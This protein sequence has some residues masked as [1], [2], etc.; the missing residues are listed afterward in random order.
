MKECEKGIPSWNQLEDW[1]RLLRRT[2]EFFEKHGFLEVV[3]PLLVPAGAF[4]SSLDCL[5][6][7]G[8]E[9]ECELPTSPEIGMKRILSHFNE[10]IYQICK[11]F[12]DEMTTSFHLKEFTM[13][14]FYQPG[15]SYEA[16]RE[17]MV[18]YLQSLSNEPMGVERVTVNE[19]FQRNLQL[20]LSQLSELEDFR[21]A[22]RER[23]LTQID[24][25]DTWPDLFFRL[26]LEKI[27]PHLDPR[28]PVMVSGY[29]LAVS[30]L[31]E[32]DADN[33][34][35]KRFEIYWRGVELC[36]GCVELK[37]HE[38]LERRYA[39]ESELR[40]RR[41]RSPHPFPA[42]LY[43]AMKKMPPAAGV[44]VGMERLFYCLFG[45]PIN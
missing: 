14:E 13:L 31:S 22:V 44:A 38:E 17:L 41:G 8:Q 9:T 3:T 27:E 40:M 18:D 34:F 37:S 30:P 11:A 23:N 33:N 10:P 1:S 4:E 12:R 36:N 25:N 19:L 20:D 24:P 5:R 43:D 35:A 26:W 2:R 21:A 15:A 16:I 7:T 28:H 42:L 39:V 6:I 32:A 29:P 45:Y